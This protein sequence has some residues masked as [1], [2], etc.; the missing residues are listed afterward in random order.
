M[1]KIIIVTRERFTDAHGKHDKRQLEEKSNLCRNF[2]N[3]LYHYDFKCMKSM[4]GRKMTLAFPRQF[5][6]YRKR[7]HRHYLQ[8][9]LIMRKSIYN[10]EEGN[11]HDGME[12]KHKK[13]KTFWLP[14]VAKPPYMLGRKA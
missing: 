1:I 3:P 7:F 10:Q 2:L 8:F 9:I 14:L 6:K 13:M 4:S 12:K 5:S 11:I